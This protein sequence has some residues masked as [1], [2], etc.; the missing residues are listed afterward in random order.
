M[1]VSRI[2]QLGMGLCI[3]SWDIMASADNLL[4]VYSQAQQ[5]DP[6]F[7]QAESTWCN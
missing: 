2:L 1:K 5:N 6:T 3:F 4:Q 7:K